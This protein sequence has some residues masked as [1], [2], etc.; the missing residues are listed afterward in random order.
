MDNK[1]NMTRHCNSDN[2]EI[3]SH[4]TKN[5]NENKIKIIVI[6]LYTLIMSIIIIIKAKVYQLDI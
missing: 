4:D 6:T 1:E 2:L 5:F 3:S